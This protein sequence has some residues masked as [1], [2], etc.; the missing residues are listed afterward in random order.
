MASV[1][2]SL[3]MIDSKTVEVRYHD[4][5]HVGLTEI[6]DVMDDLYSFTENRPLKRLVIC[7]EKSTINR[8]ARAYLQTENKKFKDIIIAEAVVV[9]SFTQK[10]ST[11]FYLAF[12]KNIF[13]SKF[14]TDEEKAIEWLKNH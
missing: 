11:N 3:K 2:K 10:M 13:P 8:E 1:L 12:M 6:V 4:N 5:V 9:T 7:T 14:F